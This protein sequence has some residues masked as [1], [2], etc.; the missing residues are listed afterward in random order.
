MSHRVT[1]GLLF[2]PRGGSAQVVRYLARG[3]ERAGWTTRLACGSLGEPGERAHAESFFA[4]L[5]V[6]AADYRPAAAAAAAGHDP[7]AEP[8]PMHPSYEDRPGAA[9]RVFAAVAPELGEHLVEAWE[10]VLAAV[11]SPAP[12]VLHLHHLTPLHEAAVRAAPRVALV[13]HL[14]GTEL[15]MID[16]AERLRAIAAGLGRSLREMAS[17]ADRGELPPASDVAPEARELFESTRWDSWRH[18]EHWLAEMRRWAASSDRLVVISPHDRQEVG[19]LL[20]LDPESAA[21]L[22]NGVDLGRFDR[23]ALSVEQRL[24]R[25]REW[26]VDEPQGWREGEATGSVGYSDEDLERFVEPSTGEAA[27]VLLFVGRFTE[28]KRIPLLLRAYARAK[29]RF[30]R[31]APLVIWGGFPGEW[32]GEHPHTVV[33]REGIEDVF[34]VGWRGHSQ[35]GEGLACSDVMVMPS[36]AESFGQVF[37][38]A[39]ACAVPVIAANAGGP[40]SFINVDAG[41]PNGW[42]VEPDSLDSLADALVEAVNDPRARAQRARSGYEVT[43]RDFSWDTVAERTAEVYDDAIAVRRRMA[44]R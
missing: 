1:M 43:R 25:W 7:T 9:D 37:V 41:R 10:P 18:G 36:I 2:Y 35:L 27:P 24:R 6:T 33:E 39:M 5:E 12:E 28:V 15:K 20:G 13:T 11:C 8:V 44:G 16:R 31:P 19:R 3:L 42:L 22:P 38:E 26:L 34:F 30:D 17:L 21:W 40:P 32:E 14:H 4:D 23:Q 29:A